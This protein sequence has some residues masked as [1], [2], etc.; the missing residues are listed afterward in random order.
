[1]K[2]RT[3]EGKKVPKKVLHYFPITSKLKRFCSSRHI[4]REVRWHNI[5]KS[6]EDEIMRHP[7]DREVL[8][9]FNATFPDFEAGP[10]KCSTWVNK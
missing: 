2:K 6:K 3:S 7:N 8:K 1:M 4:A 10:K 9:H 5:S